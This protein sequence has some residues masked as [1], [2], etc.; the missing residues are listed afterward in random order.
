MKPSFSHEDRCYGLTVRPVRCEKQHGMFDDLYEDDFF[1]YDSNATAQQEHKDDDSSSLDDF[2]LSVLAAR[3]DVDD[4]NE[5]GNAIEQQNDEYVDLGLPSGTLWATCNVGATNPWDYGDYFAWGETTTKST[6]SK[7]NYKYANGDF[8]KLT[9]YCNDISCCNNDMTNCR[10]TLE[11]KDDVA[12]QKLGSNWCMPTRRQFQELIHQCVWRWTT[13]NGIN[14]YKIEGPNDNSI[15]LPAAGF[16][17]D[18]EMR[19]R[20]GRYWSSSV[21]DADSAW[22]LYISNEEPR[23]IE[24]TDLRAAGLPVRPVR[25]KN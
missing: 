13:L 20:D 8:D 15:F 25:S 9:K 1:E 5:G 7:S 22:D 19:I 24:V 10:T 23:P 21:H 17:Y 18:S 3:Q 16:K 14:G 4:G 11:K 12:Y 6:Y 2:L